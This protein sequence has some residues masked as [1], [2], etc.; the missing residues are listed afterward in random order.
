M[1]TKNP[2]LSRAKLLV[3]FNGN[4]STLDYGAPVNSTL[5]NIV[6]G[7]FTN[8]AIAGNPNHPKLPYWSEYG[9][10]SSV[11]NMTNV[12]VLPAIDTV[13]NDRCAW[14]QQALYY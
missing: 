8:F 12:G 1:P 6:Q 5:A 14:W 7:Y 10:N 9:S 13:K 4:S 2:F 3:Y 11:Q